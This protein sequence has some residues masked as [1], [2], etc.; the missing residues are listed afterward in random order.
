MQIPRETMKKL[1]LLIAFAALAFTS[2]Q[3]VGGAVSALRF[4]WGVC[5]PFIAGA[6]IAFIV[7]VPMRFL[8][9]RLVDPLTGQN[10]SAGKRRLPRGL[11]RA[12]SILL[13]FALIAAVILLLALVVTPQ[14]ASTIAGLGKAIQS[15]LARLLR[16]A[17]TQFADNPQIAAWLAS[18]TSGWT[19]AD[20]EDM[21]ARILNFLKN[22]GAGEV[23]NSTI[24]AARG[25]ISKVTT[26][27]IAVVFSVYILMQKEKLGRQFRKAAFAL[28]P[29]RA[30][31]GFLHVCSLSHRIFSSFITG[32]CT[33]AV[34]LGF[35]FFVT[36]TV[37]RMPYALL[38]GCLIAV[39]ALIPIVGAFI[40]C[41]VGAFLILMSSPAQA[42]IF[43][44]T[45]L[46][47][48]QVE[49]NLIYPHVVGSSVGLPSIWVLAAVTIGGSLM[50]VVGM[51]I[52]I[53]LTSVLYSLFRDFVNRRLKE[54]RITVE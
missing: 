12:L 3:W 19:S 20:W 25:I 2:V 40:G 11:A 26:A 13:T 30:A 42:L 31:D 41:F 37:M 16:W 6:V 36:L 34:I 35:M 45:F 18:L 33:E 5:T 7:N 4:L 1:T 43:I 44:I 52:F 46:I 53:P 48:Q 47:L 28:L 23:V 9:G 54:R 49:G 15:T 14:L 10:R 17:Q 50:G 8:E 51:L 22:G 38:I 29:K 32:Q 39:T 27:V 21:I 24:F